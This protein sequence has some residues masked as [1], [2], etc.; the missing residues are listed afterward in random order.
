M[1]HTGDLGAK[2]KS[3]FLKQDNL[4]VRNFFQPSFASVLPTS[5]SFY[6]SLARLAS[7]TTLPKV[8][9]SKTANCANIL[10]LIKILAFFILP[11]N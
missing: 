1:I 3:L 4:A 11:I 7:S 5:S 2:S 8:S 10:R 6:H 9:G